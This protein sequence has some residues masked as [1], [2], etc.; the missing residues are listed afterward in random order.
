MDNE[1]NENGGAI[2]LKQIR[3]FAVEESGFERNNAKLSGG[4]VYMEVCSI[5]VSS[6]IMLY[7]FT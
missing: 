6:K 5:I 1:A 2:F 7:I 3:L 4:A